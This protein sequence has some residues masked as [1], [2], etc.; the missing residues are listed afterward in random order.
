MIKYLH[1]EY[2]EKYNVPTKRPSYSSLENLALK[3]TVG[4]EMRDWETALK[5]YISKVE[6]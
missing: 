3:C 1:Y 6:D 5:E 4:N 2:N